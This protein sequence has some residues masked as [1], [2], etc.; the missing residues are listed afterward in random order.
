MTTENDYGFSSVDIADLQPPAPP[1]T[2]AK[3][4]YDLIMP[5]LLNLKKDAD[6]SDI[7][8]WPNRKKIIQ[9]Q[10]DKIHTIMAE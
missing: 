9:E 1:D 8:K 10:I 2:R 6:K 7:I 5:L 3:Q 4:L